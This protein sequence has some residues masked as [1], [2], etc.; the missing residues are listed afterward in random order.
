[1]IEKL[2]RMLNIEGK[3]QDAILG[4]IMELCEVKI[5]NY[6]D[7][8]ELPEKLNGVFIEL[9]IVRYNRLASEGLASEGSDGVSVSFNN[10]FEE[11]RDELDE[12]V[13]KRDT[14]NNF[15]GVRFL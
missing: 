4:D 15:K 2:K 7:E 14:K 5:L 6:I 1:M 11:F 12:Y 13:R 8:D 9:C 10:M 3:E